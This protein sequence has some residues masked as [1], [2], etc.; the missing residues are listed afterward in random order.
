MC[1]TTT[2]CFAVQ[3]D[4]AQQLQRL[5]KE[6]KKNLETAEAMLKVQEGLTNGRKWL[7]DEAARKLG[8]LLSSPAAFEGQHFLQVMHFG[9]VESS[10]NTAVRTI[11]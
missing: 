1:W 10:C 5:Q 11:C 4:P 3:L 9:T 2:I 6:E 8:T 7:W